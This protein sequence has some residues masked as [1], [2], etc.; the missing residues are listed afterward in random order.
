MV[1]NLQA[2]I[3]CEEICPF[4]QSTLHRILKKLGF[5]YEKRGRKFALVEKPEIVLWHRNYLRKIKQCRNQGRQIFYLDESW[6]N[7]GHTKTKVWKDSMVSTA[8]QALVEGLSTGLPDPSG[9]GKRFIVAHIGNE[10]GFV[11]GGLLM[12]ESKKQ[13]DYHE[14]MT[15]EVFEEWLRHV[16]EKLPPS[17][18][19]V[20]DNAPYHSVKAEKTPTS[21][22][23]KR[24]ILA[25]L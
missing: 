19:I 6:I 3:E 9:K 16:V 13:S 1:F 4:S 23:K 18:V 8:R 25:F 5:I 7:A 12:F 15:G 2:T 21:A 17:S 14:E 22:W 24:E 20:M 10:N 11:P